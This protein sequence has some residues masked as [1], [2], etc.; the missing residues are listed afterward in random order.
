MLNILS[1][2]GPSRCGKGAIIP[3]I[4]AI[5]NF[6]L[7][8]NTP[9]L[10]W[11][12]DAYTSGDIN[13]EV[14]C[15]LATN[16][17][18]CYSWY[19]YLGRHINLRPDDYYSLQKMMP[20]INL[21]TMHSRSD[22]DKDFQEFLL[23]NDEQNYWNIF[24]W[25]IPVEAYQIIHKKYPINTN[26]L[27]CYRS[28]Y[29]LFTSWISSNRVKRSLSLSRM[30]KYEATKYLKPSSLT[31]QFE[32]ARNDNEVTFVKEL[33][34]YK[35]HKQRFEDVTIT[36]MEEEKLIRLLSENRKQAEYWYQKD[37][38][39]QFEHLVSEP[40]KFVSYMKSR[41]EV[42]F[43]DLLEKGII[44]MDKRPIEE[45]VETDFS[46]ISDTLMSMGTSRQT[47]DFVVAEQ[48]DYLREL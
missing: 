16:Y 40:Y 17:L 33:G 9:D 46:R 26:P 3:I 20:H 42:E 19:G 32:N 27:F 29:S 1:L 25:E 48:T 5:K 37:M 15:R 47:I 36:Q 12:V 35:Y 21:K 22:K 10:D 24:Q 28:P 31:Q 23:S 7:P 4:A 45:L 34:T 44:L 13:I 43:D 30:F 14:L 41:F 6:E 11:Y 39:V 2:S 38:L 18:I 8:M